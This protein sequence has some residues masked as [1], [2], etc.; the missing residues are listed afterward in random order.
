MM[1]LVLAQFTC[2]IAQ[3]AE[4]TGSSTKNDLYRR[5]SIAQLRTAQRA[6]ATGSSTKK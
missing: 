6:D 3:R 4:A 2:T 1:H 5:S